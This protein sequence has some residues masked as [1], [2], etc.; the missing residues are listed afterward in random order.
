MM[1]RKKEKRPHPLGAVLKFETSQIKRDGFLYQY[2][3][4]P[5]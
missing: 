1:V 4:Q 3:W 2:F 5:Q